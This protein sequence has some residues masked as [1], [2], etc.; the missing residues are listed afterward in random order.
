MRILSFFLNFSP[1]ATKL[2]ASDVGPTSATSSGS[3]TQQLRP[4]LARVIQAVQNEGFLVAQRAALGAFGNGGGNAPRQRANPG[5][6]EEYLI[7]GDGEFM[8]AKLLVRE[9]F[10]QCHAAKV[11][12]KAEKPE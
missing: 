11:T 1:A 2:N 5:M 3:A 10:G 9:Q 4:E 8:L 7:A 12:G 6:R